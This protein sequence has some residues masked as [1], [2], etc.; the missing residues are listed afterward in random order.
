MSTDKHSQREEREGHAVNSAPLNLASY[1]FLE[2]VG[3]WL[4]YIFGY[5]TS[6]CL[7]VLTSPGFSPKAWWGSVRSDKLLL[8]WC[9]IFE[10][11][12]WENPATSTVFGRLLWTFSCPHRFLSIAESEIGVGTDFSLESM[13][14]KLGTNRRR[15][16]DIINVLEALEMIVKQSKNWYTWLG[17]EGLLITLAKM[18]VGVAYLIECVCVCVPATKLGSAPDGH[19]PQV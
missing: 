3:V 18:R 6:H 5:H 14:K 11:H 4:L 2:R 19:E 9:G 12:S 16:Y 15:I 1:L 17:Q 7:L 13:S 8:I 10:H